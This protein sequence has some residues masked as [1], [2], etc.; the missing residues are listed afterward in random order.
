MSSNDNFIPISFWFQ[1]QIIPTCCLKFANIPKDSILFQ[2]VAAHKIVNWY[3]RM[4][5]VRKLLL[6][7]EVMVAERMKKD[8]G[9][10]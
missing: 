2:M 6:V 7:V 9:I 10:N 3:K 4:K 5:L 1:D 8:N